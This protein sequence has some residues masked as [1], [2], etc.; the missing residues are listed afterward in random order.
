M[1]QVNKKLTDTILSM[2]LLTVMAGAAIAP[3]LGV[4]KEHFSTSPALLVQFIVSIPALL[5]IITNLFF[6][7]ISRH[8]GTRQIALA[9][10][11][12]YVLASAGC[13]L[14]D[15]IYVLLTLRALLGVSVGLVMP[16][17]TGLLA[18]YY[19]PE[20][21]AHLMGLSAAMNQMGG[22]VATL[23]AGLLAGIGWQWAFLVY[24]LGVFAIVMVVRYLPDEHLGSANKRGIPFQPRQLLKFHPSVNGMLLLM[25]IFFIYPTNFAI[26]AHEQMGLG[27]HTTTLIMVGLDLIAFFAG[28]VF[29]Q[30]MQIFRTSIKYFAPLFFLVGYLCFTLAHG[31][32]LLLV[33]AVFTGVANG[34]GVPY[35][36]TIA[37]IKGGRNSAT[38]VMPLLSASL[39]LGQF[40][41]PVIVTPLAKI[42]F[43]DSDVA[44]AYKIGIVLCVIFLIQVY[45]TRHYQSLPPEE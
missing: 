12:L 45:T 8:F 24:L 38:T 42:V 32:L 25:M 28:L 19:P 14:A 17:S 15:D 34:V 44:G 1:S 31:I 40:L 5:I 29:G 22:V 30:L 6:L 3:A 26:T 35:L 20:Q 16:L 36:N 27:L 33:G 10:L 43:G 2:S 41:S 11:M 13:F 21:Q 9:G 4:I 7:N 18:Y 39:Y 23:L 37:S